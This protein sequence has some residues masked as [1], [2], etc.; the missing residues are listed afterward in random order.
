M[1]KKA[2]QQQA[3]LLAALEP[4]S[5]ASET[6]TN[7]KSPCIKSRAHKPVSDTPV[8]RRR[9]STICA[10]VAHGSAPVSTPR[11]NSASRRAALT[12]SKTI[13]PAIIDKRCAPSADDPRPICLQWSPLNCGIC[14]NHFSRSY[15]HGR[16]LAPAKVAYCRR[17]Q[18]LHCFELARLPHTRL[19]GCPSPGPARS[20]HT[21]VTAAAVTTV[22]ARRL[23]PFADQAADPMIGG[24]PSPEPQNNNRRLSELP[25]SHTALTIV[26]SV[27][28]AR[29]SGLSNQKA[30]YSLVLRVCSRGLD[31]KECLVPAI[32]AY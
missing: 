22:A 26:P 3:A 1:G 32:Q 23:A 17:P 15:P 2:K 19:A 31:I 30:R 24:E 6:A 7:P 14:L 21:S 12:S 29:G 18:P 16:R 8:H 20:Y 13:C 27:A 25:S 10:R 28:R 11:A 5:T 9:C 4:H